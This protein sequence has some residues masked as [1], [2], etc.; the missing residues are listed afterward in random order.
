MSNDEVILYM[1]RL[2][3]SLKNPYM[4]VICGD[5][6]SRSPIFWEGD[7]ENFAGSLFS[8]L[9]IS[10]NIEQLISEPTH[11]RDDGSQSCIDLICTNQPF[12]FM[13]S[14]VMPSLDPC[15]K[16]NI[17]HGKIS[18]NIPSPPTYKRKI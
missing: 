8:D 12:V 10:N 15:S 13:E 3:I 6:N 9:L 5:F 1:N 11:V 18:V 17:I 7:S 2:A 16:H 4:T 14:E